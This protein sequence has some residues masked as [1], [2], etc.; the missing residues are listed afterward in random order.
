MSDLIEIGKNFKTTKNRTGFLPI[1]EKYFHNYKNKKI[2]ILE[3][4]IDDGGSLKLWRKYFPNANIVGLDI[5]PKDFEINGVKM[6][7]GDQSNISDLKK[8]TTEYKN[9][10]IIIDDGSHVSKQTIKSFQYLFDFLKKDGLYVIEDLQTS[11]LPNFGGSRINLKKNTTMNFVKSLSDSINYELND[12]PFFKKK[13][14]DGDIKYVHFFQNI[15]FIK[16][17]KSNH[18]FYNKSVKNSFINKIKK[19][20]S[21]CYK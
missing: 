3:I 12:R 13:K 9:F 15:V 8:I 19:I 7:Q 21:F 17:G 18:Y 20:I 5:F 10:D 1:Y 16:K 14:F 6:F 2:N 4:G 11:Y